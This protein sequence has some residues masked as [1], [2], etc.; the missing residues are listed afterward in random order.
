MCRHTLASHAVF[1]FQQAA[2]HLGGFDPELGGD[3]KIA[4]LLV[5]IR[6]ET[7]A[8]R[9]A[10]SESAVSDIWQNLSVSLLT[11]IDPSCFRR[12]RKLGAKGAMNKQAHQ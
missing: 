8:S 6:E 12:Q 10:I 3:K 9:A 2:V 5:E 7:V 1:V 11:C 4:K